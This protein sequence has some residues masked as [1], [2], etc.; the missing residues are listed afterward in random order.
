MMKQQVVV[1]QIQELVEAGVGTGEI[2]KRLNAAGVVPPQAKSWTKHT[3]Y[4]L[5]P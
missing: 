1:A 2:A 5:R 4:S 3:I